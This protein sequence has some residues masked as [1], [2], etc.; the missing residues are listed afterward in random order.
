MQII[1]EGLPL[2]RAE[3]LQYVQYLQEKYPDRILDK[4]FLDAT[5]DTVAIRCE[6]HIPRPVAKMGGYYI[7]DPAHWNRAKQAE[8]RDTLPNP[9]NPAQGKAK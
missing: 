8:L 2:S 6:Y 1:M 9:V 7:G 3:Q 4:V 5:E